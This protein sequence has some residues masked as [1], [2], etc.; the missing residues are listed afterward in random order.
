MTFCVSDRPIKIE[1][2]LVY[3]CVIL[4]EVLR[5]LIL[6]AITFECLYNL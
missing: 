6:V 3:M 5:V 2:R 4:V 1:I